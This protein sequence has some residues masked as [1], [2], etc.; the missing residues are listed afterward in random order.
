MRTHSDDFEEF[1]FDDYPNVAKLMREQE[2]N[3]LRA[4][5]ARKR[6]R[7]RKAYDFRDDDEVAGDWPDDDFG[8]FEDY[9]DDEFD[10]YA[11]LSWDH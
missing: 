2:L 7:G 9:D 11:G 10:R 4:Q 8:D 5:R 1:E 6:G 3:D